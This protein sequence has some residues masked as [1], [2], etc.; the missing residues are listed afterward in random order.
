MS[1]RLLEGFASKTPEYKTVK[2]RPDTYVTKSVGPVPGTDLERDKVIT[3]DF[4]ALQNELIRFPPLFLTMKGK[5]M[6][7]A[8]NKPSSDD[9][10]EVMDPQD[11]TKEKTKRHSL[12][13][14]PLLDGASFVSKVEVM[15]DKQYVANSSLGQLQTAYTA[16]EGVFTTAE[17]YREKYGREMV[18]LSNTTQLDAPVWEQTKKN[19][20]ADELETD[21]AKK[22]ALYS[23]TKLYNKLAPLRMSDRLRKMTDSIKASA[24]D[25]NTAMFKVGLSGVFPFDLQSNILRNVSGETKPT[26]YLH[27]GCSVNLQVHLRDPIQEGLEAYGTDATLM[28]NFKSPMTG[29]GHVKL[30]L[31]E[32]T[33]QYESLT[34]TSD[35]QLGRLKANV[36]KFLP[37]SVLAQ[38]RLLAANTGM[39]HHSFRLQPKTGVSLL[40]FT[41]QDFMLGQQGRPV[42]PRSTFVPKMTELTIRLSNQTGLH[43]ILT[44]KNLGLTKGFMSPSLR[45]YYYSLI[46]RGLYDAPFE[47]WFP[48]Q[49]AE[50]GLEQA[51][52]VD[53]TP[54]NIRDNNADLLL[55]MQYA[56]T[57]DTKWVVICYNIFERE[58]SFVPGTG[59]WVIDPIS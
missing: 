42:S 43:D 33:L 19:E 13:P 2:P 59:Q 57:S 53:L 3:F 30:T 32:V 20:L 14:H 54:Y 5:I 36:Q 11:L 46:R 10:W 55:D 47:D 1:A 24:T 22:A 15:L 12:F 16:M 28:Y 4:T 45:D 9:D 48:P 49:T 18:R 44:L 37:D 40:V 8:K 21:A 52:V 50:K 26:P 38:H 23:V 39:D 29:Q 31:T 27:P 6:F 35:E 34:L 7:S 41:H 17:A 58:V 25:D 51:I 56:T